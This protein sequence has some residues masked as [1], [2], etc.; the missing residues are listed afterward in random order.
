[1]ENQFICVKDE[2]GIL[3]PQAGIWRL[4]DAGQMSALDYQKKN[5]S[6]KLIVCEIKELEDFSD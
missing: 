3:R 6:I 1:M 4:N 2:E 5:N